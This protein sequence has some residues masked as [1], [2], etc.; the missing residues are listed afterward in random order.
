MYAF[1]LEEC[2]DYR[3]AERYGRAAIDANARDAWAAHAVIHVFEMEGRQAD[4]L[5]FVAATSPD[6]G[7]SFFAVH[8]WWHSALYH[9]EL[10]QL[11]AALAVYDDRVAAEGLATPL[12]QLDA[13]SLLWRL[14]LYGVEPGDRASELADAVTAWVHDSA[15]VFNDWHA[16]MALTLAG[17]IAD[18]EALAAELPARARGTNRFMV[19]GPAST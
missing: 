17:R 15:H 8:N 19:E 13:A 9:L 11:D 18:A 5:A 14:W 1:G 16:T 4:G 12:G 6:W 3:A 10:G 7:P 2:G